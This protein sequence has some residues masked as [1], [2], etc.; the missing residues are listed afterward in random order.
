[1][2]DLLA[3]RANFLAKVEDHAWGQSTRFAPILDELIRWSQE[4]GLDYRPPTAAQ[5]LVRYAT[6]GRIFWSVVARTGD[7]AKFTLLN[8]PGFPARLRDE[9]RG[10]LARLDRKA[11]KEEGVPEV[12]L[13]KLIW[14]PYR[15]T[16]LDLMT[17]LLAQI[18][19]P[20]PSAGPAALDV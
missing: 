16:V 12:A 2:S 5:A 13:T 4:N 14:E 3:A 18:T 19:G 7:G 17:R 1:L 11:E 9:A 20:P 15:R 8:D 10:E 6:D